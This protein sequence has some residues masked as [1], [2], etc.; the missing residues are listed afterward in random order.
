[1]IRTA[2]TFSAVLSLV[3]LVGC[4]ELPVLACGSEGDSRRFQSELER[5]SDP[6]RLWEAIVGASKH[7]TVQTPAQKKI[8]QDAME[9]WASIAPVSDQRSAYAALPDKA[10]DLRIA[11]L[12]ATDMLGMSSE[13]DWKITESSPDSVGNVGRKL[14]LP[15][16]DVAKLTTKHKWLSDILTASE[17][18]GYRIYV[19]RSTKSY[20]SNPDRLLI[21]VPGGHEYTIQ[22]KT[23]LYE[24]KGTS[25]LFQVVR[26]GK[27]SQLVLMVRQ[28]MLGANGRSENL[29][30]YQLATGDAVRRSGSHDGDHGISGAL[31]G[32]GV[33]KSN[34]HFLKDAKGNVLYA[35]ATEG[36][37]P[38]THEVGQ[39]CSV[40]RKYFDFRSDGFGEIQQL[41]ENKE[42]DC[43]ALVKGKPITAFSA[44]DDYKKLSQWGMGS[45]LGQLVDLDRQDASD[46]MLL[47]TLRSKAPSSLLALIQ[48]AK[49]PAKKVGQNLA[50]VSDS[51][52]AV[53]QSI[54]QLRWI[55]RGT[56]Y[57]QTLNAGLNEP[58]SRLADL[59]PAVNGIDLTQEDVARL[60]ALFDQY[61]ELRADL[62]REFPRDAGFAGK[63]N[64]AYEIRDLGRNSPNNLAV[65]LSEEPLPPGQGPYDMLVK[66]LGM[67]EAKKTKGGSVEV[68]RYAVIPKQE[69][70]VWG[71]YRKIQPQMGEFSAK[72]DSFYQAV[73]NRYDQ[74]PQALL[75]GTFPVFAVVDTPLQA[76]A[77]VA[78]PTEPSA[79]SAVPP[80]V[81]G[82]AVPKAEEAAAVP[83]AAATANSA[84]TQ[85]SKKL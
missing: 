58:E 67:V 18:D 73:L 25:P 55:F 12:N 32:R 44:A 62:V 77:P 64:H 16:T 54:D 43:S 3:S 38:G 29:T 28:L 8:V 7:C 46:E 49:P 65:V 61:I 70:I 41:T 52:K 15:A 19:T 37:K 5:Q 14:T 22:L 84:G 79:E 27:E 20:N 83:D 26:V 85:E 51:L 80:G 17:V 23:E 68:P 72:V 81:A 60:K 35:I 57:L 31:A 9:R 45:L 82:E 75:T 6:R 48:K 63:F 56:P 4:N 59:S 53:K 66:N 39:A 34:L 47:Q 21:E 10:I 33:G 69:M 78:D 13:M 71:K 74:L 30:F 36:R 50:D 40:S 2:F 1:M 42:V 11:L 76:V 24:P